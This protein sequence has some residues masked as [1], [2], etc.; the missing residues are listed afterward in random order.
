VVVC[1]PVTTIQQRTDAKPALPQ[2]VDNG[3]PIPVTVVT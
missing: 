3:R 2:P 1:T